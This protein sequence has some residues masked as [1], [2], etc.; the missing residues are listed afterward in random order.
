MDYFLNSAK[1]YVNKVLDKN[2]VDHVKSVCMTY[3]EHMVFSLSISKKFLNGVCYSL[4]HSFFPNYCITKP[5]EIANDIIECIK[6]S[7]CRKDE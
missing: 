2:N 1:F 3:K 4:I 5:S 6:E 7:G